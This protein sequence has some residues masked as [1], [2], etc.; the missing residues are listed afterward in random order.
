[1]FTSRLIFFTE[2]FISRLYW[3]WERKS[4]SSI[5]K[6]HPVLKPPRLS[7]QCTR[8]SVKGWT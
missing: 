8:G 3:I 5:Y 6:P 4:L 2:W 7:V 1:L